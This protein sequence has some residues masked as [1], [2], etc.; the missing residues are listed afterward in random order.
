MQKNLFSITTML[1][2]F[3]LVGC[4]TK[5]IKKDKY[6]TSSENSYNHKSDIKYSHPTM[7]PYEIMGI[8]YFPITVR[9][10]D[11]FSGNASW[12]GPDFH[13]KL[14][15][16]GEVYDMMKMTAAH[17]TLP[18]NTLL[19][20]TNKDNGL[21]TVVRVNDR[22]PFVATRIIDLSKAA[23]KKLDMIKNGT[24]S[25]SIEVIGFA[26]TKKIKKRLKKEKKKI[27]KK[28]KMNSNFYLQIGSFAKIDGAI[29]TQEKYDGVDG[30]KTIIKDIQRENKRIFK[31]LL[32]G[33]KNHQEIVAYKKRDKGYFHSAF[34]VKGD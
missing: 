27:S 29:K 7:K 15:S 21:S 22:G 30:Y 5:G 11:K 28:K 19:K 17:K 3:N 8:K 13:G 9:V 23:A 24:A 1:L 25:I 12:Y 33:F 6:R 26:S 34:I 14:T 2:L 32:G 10:G 16:N 4:S 18:M 20:V 31:V